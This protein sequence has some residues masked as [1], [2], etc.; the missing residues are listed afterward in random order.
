MDTVDV[1]KVLGAGAVTFA[2]MWVLTVYACR[3]YAQALAEGRDGEAGF[4]GF[5]AAG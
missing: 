3:M 1:A 4:W 5:L 2:I